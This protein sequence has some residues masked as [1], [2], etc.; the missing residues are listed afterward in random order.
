MSELRY[1]VPS[2][3]TSNGDGTS[4]LKS[5]SKDW[6]SEGGEGGGYKSVTPR[7]G[8]DCNLPTE[9]AQLET[10]QGGTNC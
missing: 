7:S 1:S 4:G 10:T 6:S 9:L 3:Q 2:T 5:H 8:Y